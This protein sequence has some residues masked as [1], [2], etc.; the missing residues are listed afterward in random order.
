VLQ[1]YCD[2]DPAKVKSHQVRF[3]S[4]VF[5]GETITV[6][7]WKDGDVVSFEARIKERGVTVIR[8]GKTQLG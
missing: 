4:P 6:D 2:F 7:L 5:P 3:S 8:N 1:E